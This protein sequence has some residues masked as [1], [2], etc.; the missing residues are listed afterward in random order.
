[1]CIME[2]AHDVF[3]IDTQEA[4]NEKNWNKGLKRRDLYLPCTW[5]TMA[6][7]RMTVSRCQQLKD[8]SQ[9]PAIQ[10]RKSRRWTL[11]D[12]ICVYIQGIILHPDR[13]GNWRMMTRKCNGRSQVAAT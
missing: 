3:T 13:H 5:M 4:F 6:M 7:R 11:L 9:V 8:P 12:A 10:L 2:L 1:M